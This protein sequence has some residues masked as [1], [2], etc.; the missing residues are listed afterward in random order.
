MKSL[1]DV[2]NFSMG[3]GVLALPTIQVPYC[4]SL[5]PV[6]VAGP[7]WIAWVFSLGLLSVDWDAFLT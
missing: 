7:V 6:A 2:P 3:A 1:S 4:S 5:A